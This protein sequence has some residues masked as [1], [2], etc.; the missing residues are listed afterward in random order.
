MMHSA[1]HIPQSLHFSR[2]KVK[3]TIHSAAKW[4][5]A[6]LQ[7]NETHNTA[8]NTVKQYSHGSRGLFTLGLDP[9]LS[10]GFPP[11]LACSG[12]ITTIYPIWAGFDMMTDR[13]L[14]SSRFEKS[15][16][17]LRLVIGQSNCFRRHFGQCS[18]MKSFGNQ[19]QT[20]GRRTEF[21]LIW[22]DMLPSCLIWTDVLP[23]GS[24]W[25]FGLIFLQVFFFMSFFKYTFLVLMVFRKTKK[26]LLPLEKHFLILIN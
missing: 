26:H 14:L 25:V 2:Q 3:E 19:K 22:H 7:H 4:Q 23:E 1:V 16:L 5:N 21:K 10:E 8:N 15:C 9:L 18:S 11:D 6:A 13:R 20:E 17:W 12:Q 24:H